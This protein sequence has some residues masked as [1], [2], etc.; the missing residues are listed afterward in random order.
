MRTAAAMTALVVIAKAPLAGRSKTRLT[1]PLSHEQAAALAEASLRD[2]LA[3]VCATPARRRVLVLDG[4]P[5]SWLP[6][7]VELLAQ[8]GAGLDERLANAFEDLGGPAL[9]VGMDTP[10][11]TPSLLELGLARLRHASAVLGPAA[12]GGYWAIGLQRADPRALLDVPMSTAHTALA[13]RRR[14]REL[15]LR[16]EELPQ[17][18]DVDTY[19]DA[20]SVAA[21]APATRFAAALTRV[22]PPQMPS[23]LL[24]A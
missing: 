13:Q 17:L 24:T 2:T 1:P 5:G 22:Q 3:A 23:A 18:R 19:G 10:Q 20:V 12:D 7:G 16:V 11:L 14:L 8:R 15:G 9:I 6:S 21:L 4:E